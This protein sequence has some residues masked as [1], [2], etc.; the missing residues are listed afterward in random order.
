MLTIGDVLS[1]PKTIV[2]VRQKRKSKLVQRQLDI[3][4]SSPLDGRFAAFVRVNTFLMESFSIGLTYTPRK[5]RTLILVRVNGDHGL[6]QN[7][8]GTHDC[9]NKPHL[10][11]PTTEEITRV[12]PSRFEPKYAKPL[13]GDA[14]NL[15]DAWGIFLN[16]AN[17]K[18]DDKF[19]RI[20][21]GLHD[22]GEQLSL[23]GDDDG[24]HS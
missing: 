13:E 3:E 23:I 15:A 10:H 6:H 8:D 17:V 22:R 1:V 2:S 9:D 16:A 20:I 7:P 24:F 5:S 19:D 14:R 11:F 4:L 21:A 18:T 12:V